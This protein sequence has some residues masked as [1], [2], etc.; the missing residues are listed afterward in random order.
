MHE[1]ASRRK[2]FYVDADQVPSLAYRYGAAKPTIAAAKRWFR[3]I[4]SGFLLSDGGFETPDLK[5]FANDHQ[6]IGK[7][8]LAEYLACLMDL[9]RR[10]GRKGGPTYRK[11]D[12]Y[13]N[14]SDLRYS[15]IRHYSTRRYY[16]Y[17]SSRCSDTS[18]F[19]AYYDGQQ[20]KPPVGKYVKS[21]DGQLAHIPSEFK[22]SRMCIDFIV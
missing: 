12:Y 8:K 19:D 11:S 13:K 18:F 5:E 14:L 21:V 17:R 10:D 20:P 3:L 2:I 16:A 6:F 22:N 1:N 7:Q 9:R 4:R 15:L